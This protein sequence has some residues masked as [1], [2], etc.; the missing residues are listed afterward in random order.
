MTGR[1]PLTVSCFHCDRTRA[2]EQGLI[3]PQGIDL[4]CLPH[5][6]KETFF[7]MMR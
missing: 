3:A 4:T 2:V 6:P 1:I 7:R 5:A